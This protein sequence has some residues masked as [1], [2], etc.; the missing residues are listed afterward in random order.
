MPAEDGS[1]LVAFCRLTERRP[2]RTTGRRWL[3]KGPSLTVLPGVRGAGGQSRPSEQTVRRGA[4]RVG[5]GAAIVRANARRELSLASLARVVSGRRQPIERATQDAC[6]P[7]RRYLLPIT[8]PE[9]TMRWMRKLIVR[10]RYPQAECVARLP[11]T[12][13][14]TGAYAARLLSHFSQC[15]TGHAISWAWGD[16]SGGVDAQRRR[17]GRARNDEDH[18]GWTL[19]A[20]T[21]RLQRPCLTAFNFSAS[22]PS[23]RHRSRLSRR[24]SS[25]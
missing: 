24:L 4:V 23:S 17:W 10:A 14:A 11:F 21:S 16:R 18:E 3:S 22:P 1:A 25:P 19:V 8:P 13:T 15:W 5:G 9:R 7:L 2:P 20:V 6:E 12:R